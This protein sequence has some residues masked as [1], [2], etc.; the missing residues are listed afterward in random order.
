MIRKPLA[1]LS[2]AVSV[3]I[4]AAG[5]GSSS[6]STTTA[7]PASSTTTATATTATTATTNTGTGSTNA[8]NPAVA[9]AVAACKS[10]INS[11]PQLSS[12]VKSKLIQ[13]CDQAANGNEAGARKAA[14]QVCVEIIKATV[15]QSVQAQALAGCPKA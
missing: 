8:A 2:V 15:P 3:G 7:A 10:R 14:A 6:S 5:C 12:S 4:L 1:L 9:E 13:I 11:A